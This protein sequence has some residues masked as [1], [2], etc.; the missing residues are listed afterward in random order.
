MH[1]FNFYYK[2]FIRNKKI[3]TIKYNNILWRSKI[4][5]CRDKTSVDNITAVDA[6]FV[7]IIIIIATILTIIIIAYI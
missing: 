1:E 4:L 7:V 6:L 2:T 3:L 5:L